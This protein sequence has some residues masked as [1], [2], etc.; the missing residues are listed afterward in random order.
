MAGIATW[1][2][3]GEKQLTIE[4]VDAKT[5]EIDGAISAKEGEL[6]NMRADLSVQVLDGDL[7]GGQRIAHEEN[8]LRVLRI[9]K[10][11]LEATAREL[12]ARDAAEVERKAWEDSDAEG[13]ALI[14]QSRVVEGL[15]DALAP[16]LLKLIDHEGRHRKS[17]PTIASDF[18]SLSFLGRLPKLVAWRIQLKTNDALQIDRAVNSYQIENG[19]LGDLVALAKERVA[20][21][22][23]GR[24]TENAKAA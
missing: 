19:R 2:R 1:F 17:I 12:R 10:A 3:R 14:E 20:M 15:L 6:T 16:A 21:G 18:N 13:T 9:T 7:L 24:Q 11:E 5:S 22:R 4:N 8:N 23:K